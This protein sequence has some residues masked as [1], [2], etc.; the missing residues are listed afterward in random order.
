[1][2]IAGGVILV[3]ALSALLA[4]C[5][6]RSAATHTPTP[7][8]TPEVISISPTPTATP[9]PTPIS[10]LTHTPTPVP[11]HTAA[12]TATTP[13]QIPT[14]TVSQIPTPTSPAIRT[15]TSAP[16]P[17]PTPTPTLGPLSETPEDREGLWAGPVDTTGSEGFPVPPWLAIR[18][19]PGEN[20]DVDSWR[21][22]P[23]PLGDALP[24]GLTRVTPR[25]G[26]NGWELGAFSGPFRFTAFVPAHGDSGLEV[27]IK[28]PGPT[29]TS[30]LTK[31]A[32]RDEPQASPN[33]SLVW[34][35]RGQGIHSDI[36]AAGGL[37]F[38][39]HISDRHIEVLD[40]AS[41]QML[42]TASVPLAGRGEPNF[43]F[44]VKAHDGILYAATPSQGIAIFDISRP[45]EPQIIGQHRVFVGED[46]PQNFTNIHNIFL[47]PDGGHLY[48]INQSF[49]DT[50]LRILDVSDPSSPQEAGRFAIENGMGPGHGVHD[51][52]VIERGGR[53]IAFLNYLK[54]GLWV[55]DV[56]D[57]SSIAVLGSI[58]WDDI[59][60]HSGWPFELN[61]KL[62]YA[63]TS[64]GYD[65]HLA[66]LDVTDFGDLRVVSRFSTRQGL[67]IHNVQVVDGVAYISYYI[68]GLRVVDL[69]DPENPREI[70]HSD[71]VPAE[72]ERGIAQ[73]AW[74][75]RV[76]DGVVYISDIETG[77]Y[78]F[79]VDLGS[80]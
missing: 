65:R 9:L 1:M 42:G 66:V 28:T 52:N 10:V 25:R 8:P 61:G 68:D 38:A 59:F 62:Y 31:V 15:P 56:T 29:F 3:L 30:T 64:E 7:S 5:D 34:K 58:K 19:I 78:A 50:D 6:R 24:R 77:T 39:P 35:Q 60:S 22:E 80:A 45:F 40:A 63:H 14:P 4:A 41:G 55:L 36:W 54:E 44:D 13:V 37:V 71:T 33:V 27:E 16:T 23:G 53:L 73:G 72:E 21:L 20:P 48:A 32:Q 75:V 69:R 79:Q 74:G 49:P 70:G 18:V 57:P 47:S 17:T 76:A 26:Q 43:V 46:S 2:R 67:S 11:T 51:I 12:P